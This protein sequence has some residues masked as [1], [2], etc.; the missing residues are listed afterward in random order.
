MKNSGVPKPS[1]EPHHPAASVRAEHQP[2]RPR[3]PCGQDGRNPEPMRPSH[4]D[5]RVKAACFPPPSLCVGERWYRRLTNDEAAV[6]TPDVRCRTDS[7][8]VV[9]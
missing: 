3:Q 1:G 5:S 9:A 6:G 7:R 4:T 8:S 2:S